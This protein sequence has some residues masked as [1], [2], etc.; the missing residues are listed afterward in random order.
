[1]TARLTA[2]TKHLDELVSLGLRGRIRVPRF[3]RSLRWK[4]DDV[5]Q[6]FD[7]IYRGYPIG[8]ILMWSQPTEGGDLQT[9]G[10]VEVP[11]PRQDSAWWVVDGQQRITS[12]VAGLCH[13]QPDPS[14]PD[15]PYVVYF[16]TENETFERGLSPVP[17][18][19][20]PLHLLGDRRRFQR[21]LVERLDLPGF[22]QDTAHNLATRIRDYRV[23]VYFVEDADEQEVRE[24]FHRVN[25]AGKRM[26]AHEVFDALVGSRSDRP[27][28]LDALAAR[29]AD[30]GFGELDPDALAQCALALKDLDVT[31]RVEHQGLDGYADLHGVIPDLDRALQLALELLMEE[32]RVP[33]E[34]LLP[35]RRAPLITLTRFFHLF[36]EPSLNARRLLVRWIW[37]GLLTGRHRSSDQTYLRACIRAVRGTDEESVLRLL[38]D[39]PRDPAWTLGE[40]FDARNA[41]DRVAILV[42]STLRPLELETGRRLDVA[43]GLSRYGSGAIAKVVPSGDGHGSAANRILGGGLTPGRIR[44]ALVGAAPEITASHAITE[45][46]IDAL[47]AGRDADFCALR[48]EALVAVV[49]TAGERYAEWRHRDRRSLELVDELAG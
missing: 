39:V 42:L 24:I 45:E 14:D 18:T 1:M 29:S 13:P 16:D 2:E 30:Y 26:R 11:V 38:A 34:R 17:E 32:A 28:R 22:D 33:H 9:F 10:P 48:R 40:R 6:L 27:D 4:A 12:L 41:G 31:R 43:D 5:C 19:W 47:R 20:I 46:A 36:P 3:Q 7:S 21:W 23:P 44:R 49:G 25:D 15:D 8:T 35:Y 37:R